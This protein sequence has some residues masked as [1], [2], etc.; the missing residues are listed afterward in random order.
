M[1]WA[2]VVS[3]FPAIKRF[4]GDYQNEW[5]MEASFNHFEK[6]STME[7]TRAQNFPK[8]P[9]F[10]LLPLTRPFIVSS[11]SMRTQWMDSSHN[12]LLYKLTEKCFILTFSV[13]NPP[14]KLQNVQGAPQVVESIPGSTL[15]AKGLLKCRWRNE[16]IGMLRTAPF[17]II[18]FAHL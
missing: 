16:G 3:I 11:S 17:S 2:F 14:W 5:L 8:N 15:Y 13:V 10:M 1:E 18:A 9:L 4:S 12:R 6:E 7:R